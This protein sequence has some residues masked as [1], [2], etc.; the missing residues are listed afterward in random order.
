MAARASIDV[1]AL[2]D[3]AFTSR[4]PI[5]WG[6]FWMMVIE[7]TVILILIAA[8]FYARMGFDVWPPPRIAVPDLTMGAIAT[9]LLLI[10]VAPMYL[11]DKSVRAGHITRGMVFLLIGIAF[12]VAVLCIRWWELV[13]Y[14]FKWSTGQF[15]SYAWALVGLHTIHLVAD[16]LE[17]AVIF[18]I[19][20]LRPVGGKQQ[21]A[22]EVD[23][24]YWYFVVLIWIPIFLSIY[25]YPALSKP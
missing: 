12:A 2:P 24:L 17:S 5:W 9:V 15:G 8:Y 13:H 14:N 25:V 11:S 21:Q 10:S 4:S 22:V 20:W 6:Q 7:S 1:S 18:I 23:G 19:F 16:T 3:C